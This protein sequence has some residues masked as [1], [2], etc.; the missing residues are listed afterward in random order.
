MENKKLLILSDD[1]PDW[2]DRVQ[3]PNPLEVDVIR[4]KAWLKE[5]PGE[6]KRVSDLMKR[7]VNKLL[8]GYSLVREA[9]GLRMLEMRD[10][11]GWEESSILERVL[12]EQVCFCWLRLHLVENTHAP[13]LDGSHDLR[14]GRYWE[15]RLDGAQKRF[16]RATTGLA[17]VRKLLRTIPR[18]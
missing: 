7:V 18:Q 3:K 8:E 2:F 12:I 11:L 13:L 15:R 10:E 16:V 17:R 1:K 4:M 5:R 14:T 6:W 9:I